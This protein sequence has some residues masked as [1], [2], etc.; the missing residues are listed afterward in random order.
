MS[1][2]RTVV[3]SAAPPVRAD[4]RHRFVTRDFSREPGLRWVIG[5]KLVRGAFA[6]LLAATLFV[7][8]ATGHTHQLHDAALVLKQQVSHAWTLMLARLLVDASSARHLYLAAVALALDGGLCFAEGWC[9][10]RGLRWGPLLVLV[11]TG[12]L[13]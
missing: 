12:A 9:L 7:L 13:I 8:A 6:L 1:S 4:P 5:Y 11:T 2:G 3:A 10:Y